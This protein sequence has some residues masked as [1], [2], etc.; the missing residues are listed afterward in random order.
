MWRIVLLVA[1]VMFLVKATGQFYYYNDK[2]YDQP[3]IVEGGFSVG[4]MNCFTD[5][6][7]RK[8]NGGKWLKDLNRETGSVAK[9]IFLSAKYR[10]MLGMRLEATVGRVSGADSLLKKSDPKN[11][12]YI[13]NLHFASSISELLLTGEL[14]F[15]QW[16]N[17]EERI[18]FSPYITTGIGIY[19]FSPEAYIHGKAYPLQPMRTEGQGFPGNSLVNPYKLT[20]LNVPAGVGILYEVSALLVLRMEII[21]RFLNTDYL[22]DVSGRYV[23][24][25]Q[26]FTFHPAE[27]A[28]VALEMADRRTD[29]TRNTAGA[30]R[31]NAANK[32]SYFSINLKLGIVL[33]R[34]SRK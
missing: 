24:T 10:S 29:H 22:D 15:L 20:Q 3:L 30:I 32:D 1:G 9:G 16:L 26:F 6:G 17:K 23:E 27:Y 11:L 19:H 34:K 8:G 18:A 31:G 21:Y 33:N 14:Y 12:R 13:R 5:L 25:S 7:G 28:M 2:Y 4:Y